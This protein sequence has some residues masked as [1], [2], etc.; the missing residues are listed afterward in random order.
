MSAKDIAGTIRKVM[1]NGTVYRVPADVNAT[2]MISG[3]ENSNVPTSGKNMRKMVRRSRN[4]EGMTLILNTDELIEL[5]GISEQLANVTL[6]FTLAAGDTFR[7]SG[8]I[9]LESIETEEGRATVTL[10][11]E[12]DW[13]PSVGEVS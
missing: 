10:L 8:T 6:G 9:E 4:V 11:P 12:N 3:Y 7:A 13:T 1:I 5:K 2:I